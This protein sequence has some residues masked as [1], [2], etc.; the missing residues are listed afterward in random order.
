MV[1]VSAAAAGKAEL[2]APPRKPAFYGGVTKRATSS[3][4]GTLLGEAGEIGSDGLS[5]SALNLP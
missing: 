4:F 2:L 1:L 3:I 5:A